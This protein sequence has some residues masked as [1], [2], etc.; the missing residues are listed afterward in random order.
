[1]YLLTF[2]FIAICSFFAFASCSAQSSST[3]DNGLSVVRTDP[4]TALKTAAALYKDRADL[5]KAKEAIKTLEKA[6]NPDNRNYEVEWKFARYCYFLGSRPNLSDEVSAKSLKK[7]LEAAKIASRMQPKKPDGHFWHAAI[8]GEQSRRSPVTVGI[9]SINKIKEILNKVIEI[10]PS[11]AGAS[12]YDA[13]GQL[14]LAT[15]RLGG[16]PEKALEYFKKAF[17]LDPENKYIHLHLA[18]VYLALDRDAEAK[19]Y[20]DNLLETKA[21][22]D[23]VPEHLEILEKAKKLLKQK[24]QVL[25]L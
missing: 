4:A 24:F 2:Y 3:P 21:H 11:Y 8:L 17:A 9:L 19:K 15:Q 7:G 6:R 18:E 16:D 10:D 20:L 14:E 22:P 5:D 25:Q 13:L 1:M 12:P 23:F